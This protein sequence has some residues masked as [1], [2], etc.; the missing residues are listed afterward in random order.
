MNTVRRTIG[1]LA[2]IPLVAIACTEGETP[3]GPELALTGAADHSAFEFSQHFIVCKEGTDASFDYE[4]VAYGDPNDPNDDVPLDAGSF[5]LLDGNCT[6]VAVWDGGD[7]N[8]EITVTEQAGAYIFVESSLQRFVGND[9]LSGSPVVS[10]TGTVSGRIGNDLGYVAT[11]TNTPC[12][13][14]IGDFVWE[15]LNGNG[16]QDAGEPGIAGV[17]VNLL[18]G[19]GATIGTA[20]TDASGFYLFSGL[21]AGDYTVDVDG[22]TVPAGYVQTPTNVGA[23]PTIDNNP[24]PTNVTLPA[25]DTSDLTIDFGYWMPPMADE[26]CTPGYY[27]NLKKHLFAWT[28]AGYDPDQS[29]ASV[30]GEAANAPYAALGAATLHEGLS[31][32]GGDSL[33]EKAEILLRAAIA[34]VLNASNPNVSYAYTAAGVIADV[35]AAL[36]SGDASEIL[37]LAADLDSANNAGCPLGNG[38]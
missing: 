23:D 18:D 10:T 30:F 2:L 3:A 9:V 38:S 4:V 15:D 29:V 13:G 11:F 34:A 5:S 21:C 31:F 1:A 24:D 36:A 12:T 19:G 35:N 28:D 16:L 37:S 20:V 25:N 32:Q 26:G 8:K 17:T 22:T 27:K 14:E 33:E 7:P 6:T